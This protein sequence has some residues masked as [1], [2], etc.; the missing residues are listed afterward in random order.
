VVVVKGVEDPEA[1]KISARDLEYTS[2]QL[3][4]CNSY[5]RGCSQLIFQIS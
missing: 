1:D 2:R 3:E 4:S 5:V